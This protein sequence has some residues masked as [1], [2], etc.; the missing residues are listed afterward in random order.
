M[1][2]VGLLRHGEARGG[3]RLRGH[4][5]DPLTAHGRE[6]M[7]AATRDHFHWDRVI[8]SPLARCAEFARTFARRQALP[9]TLDDR[10]KELHFGAWEGR[11]AAGLMAETPDA[12]TRFW[13]DP[14][15]YPPPDGEPLAQFQARVLD[16]WRAIVT[17]PA[18]RRVL[19][20]THGGVIRVLLCHLHRQPIERLLE[21]EV[22]LASLHQVHVEHAGGEPQATLVRGLRP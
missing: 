16:A 20:V 18:D 12:L 21:L 9:L 19:V 15:A 3:A 13:A 5:D 14:A 4:T 7:H 22:G 1:I 17:G 8:S 6:Q 10:L 11:T 2:L